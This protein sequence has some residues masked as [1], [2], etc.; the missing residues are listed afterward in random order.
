MLIYGAPG[1]LKRPANRS[2]VDRIVRSLSMR[3]GRSPSPIR[4]RAPIVAQFRVT[5]TRGFVIQGALVYALGLP[6]SWTANAAEQP[7]D[8]SGWATIT[9]HPLAGMPI[10]RSGALVI[11]VG[12][13]LAE[14]RSWRGAAT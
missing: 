13:V 2:I 1:E 10:G 11:F 6:Y 4:S 5:D 12:I 7:T 8:A 3:K 9:L 14:S